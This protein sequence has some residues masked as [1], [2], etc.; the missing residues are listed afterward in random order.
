MILGYV[1]TVAT[2]PKCGIGTES[3][4]YGLLLGRSD[5][6]ASEGLQFS[7]NLCSL[8]LVCHVHHLSNF[9]AHKKL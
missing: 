6:T 8:K 4:M 5:F 2:N 1:I 9:S 7:P 3:M